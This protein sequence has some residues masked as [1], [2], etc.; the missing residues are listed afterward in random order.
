MFVINLDIRMGD[1]G[2][3][4]FRSYDVLKALSLHLPFSI[5]RKAKLLVFKDLECAK[6]NCSC[7][8]GL[9]MP[10]YQCLS[11]PGNAG[12]IHH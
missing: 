5:L 6:L 2:F 4:T 3:S 11:S 10:K 7:V 8:Q 1:Q 9:G 12:N